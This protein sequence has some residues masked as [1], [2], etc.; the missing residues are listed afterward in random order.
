[1]V[2]LSVNYTIGVE[3][4]DSTETFGALSEVSHTAAGE[5]LVLDQNLCGVK[6]FGSD[7]EYICQFGRSGS[8]PG[9]MLM[10]LYVTGLND[11]RIIVNDPMS[12]AFVSYD[13][14]FNYIENIYLWDN[15]PPVQ[16]CPAAGNAFA[17][18]L[19][20]FDM[21]REQPM[22]TRT[23]GIFAESK[24]PDILVFEDEV[25]F[26]FLISRVF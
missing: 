15:G 7:G 24:E 8:G 21:E 25:P 6:V 26:D 20:G 13:S 22:I 17:G 3:T 23:L 4:G 1:M 2:S 10:P 12:N 18:V 14:A 19:T 11:G 5:I 16:G 9:E